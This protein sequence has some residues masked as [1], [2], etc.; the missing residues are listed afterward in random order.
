MSGGVPATEYHA[1]TKHSPESV[2]SGGHGLDFDNKPRPYK[3]YE[4]VDRE[5]LPDPGR[6]EWP[7]TLGVLGSSAGPGV[8]VDTEGSGS[9]ATL[10]R[11]TLS[12]LCH[13]AAGV[14]RRVERGG[15]AVA[16][17]AAACTG[18]LYHVDLY[19]V[20]GDLP[21]AGVYHYDPRTHAL[22]VLRRGDY[23]GV[24]SEATGGAE[25]V[26]DAPVS[27]VATSTWWRNAW[28]YRA[29][30][31]RHAFWDAGTVLANLLAGATAEGLPASVVTGFEDARLADLL[32]VAPEREAPVAVV[33][34]GTD[35]GDTPPTPP[36]VDPLSLST[37]PLSPDEKRFSLITEAYEAS[38]LSG[39][40]AVCEWRE[41]GVD[42]ASA[43]GVG[44]APPGDG[45]RLP[46]DPVGSS[47]AVRTPLDWTVRRRG[48]CR[49]F[50]RDS[51]SPR[52]V[53]TVFD[54]ALSGFPMDVRALDGPTLQY[55]DLFLV[56][57]D[58]EGVPRGTYQYHADGGE[59][60]PELE[61]LAEGDFRRRAGQIALDQR[62]AADAGVCA[63]FLA[64]L[65]AVTDRLGDRGYRAAQLEA[66]LA[67]GRLYLAAYAHS[68][69]GATGLTFYDDAV[70]DLFEPRAD[71]RTPMFLWVLG[72]PA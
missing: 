9:P 39:S 17:R 40:G 55:T 25:G 2:R 42:A 19:L 62:L 59:G 43:G 66:S 46:L 36:E 15:E 58:V 61:R 63:F 20:C 30:T 54:R 33:S 27:V 26:A 44:S 10:D 38:S 49:E 64:D 47:R 21:Y 72:R 41:G 68:D 70:T 52:K 65:G 32:G 50:V 35:A 23:R 48:S 18:A 67:A 7:P 22:D 31:Y 69:L 57:N 4:D 5:S 6:P 37:R 14:T 53:A 34:L 11:A 13:Y 28:K 12:R 8:D 56:V 16:F 45:D 3:V 24:V 29:R 51:L 1:R 71:G 60:A